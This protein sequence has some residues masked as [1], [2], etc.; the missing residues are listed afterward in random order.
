MFINQGS[1]LD[2]QKGPCKHDNSQYAAPFPVPCYLGRVTCWR[3][4][5]CKFLRALMGFRARDVTVFICRRHGVS[6]FR[7]N[8]QSLG[9]LYGSFVGLGVGH[10]TLD[11]EP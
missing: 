5:S 7:I 1:T 11:N 2:A 8:I 3:K 10:I 6:G 9:W 4:E